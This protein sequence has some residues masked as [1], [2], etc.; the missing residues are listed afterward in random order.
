MTRKLVVLLA[1]PTV[2]FALGATI[3]VPRSLAVSQ[4]AI[5][6]IPKDLYSI[7]LIPSPI[8]EH[9]VLMIWQQ[10][11][12]AV[13]R[14]GRYCFVAYGFQDQDTRQ[15]MYLVAVFDTA[16]RRYSDVHTLGVHTDKCNRLEYPRVDVSPDDKHIAV[17][18]AD[19]VWVAEFDSNR[20]KLMP[21]WHASVYDG[22]RPEQGSWHAATF[23]KF[24]D[25]GKRLYATVAP[26]AFVEYDVQTG[27]CLRR[28]D[29]VKKLPK[30]LQH[31]VFP[32]WDLCEPAGYVVAALDNKWLFNE[33]ANPATKQLQALC[34]T[35]LKDGSQK[36]LDLSTITENWVVVPLTLSIC[37]DPAHPVVAVTGSGSVGEDLQVIDLESLTAVK[38]IFSGQKFR[39]TSAIFSP[40]GKWLILGA[41]SSVRA[42]EPDLV[43]LET[44][45]W[46]VRARYRI[47][48]IRNPSPRFSH[49]GQVLALYSDDGVLAKLSWP[50]L[51]EHFT[52][53]AGGAAK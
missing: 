6:D 34:L 9:A 43:I 28:L 35:R 32:S 49:D 31:A 20:G 13:S 24:A 33:D 10:H 8:E 29:H 44:G 15:P 38:P 21:R 16:A 11:T 51:V 40:D 5:V 36:L 22:P 7:H 23:V 53:G 3:W 14:D 30:D 27:R 19:A 12:Y 47:L 2:L 4:L 26:V 41:H 17:G 42:H 25:D 48:E 50:R 37:P 1:V 18:L 45:R 52:A 39:F 46:R